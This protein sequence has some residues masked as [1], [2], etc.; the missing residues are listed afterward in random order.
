MKNIYPKYR[1]RIRKPIGMSFEEYD[2]LVSRIPA[3]GKYMSEIL[4]ICQDGGTSAEV[5]TLEDVFVI[6]TEE[7]T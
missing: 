3:T 7:L 6:D 5:Y 1:A 2:A 4:D